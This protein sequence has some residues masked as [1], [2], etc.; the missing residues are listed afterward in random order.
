VWCEEKEIYKIKLPT[1]QDTEAFLSDSL[2]G[3]SMPSQIVLADEHLERVE[4]AEKNSRFI[5]VIH[6][7]RVNERIGQ[8]S[9]NYGKPVSAFVVDPPVM[10]GN[11]F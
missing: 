3:P 6:I 9:A 7:L 11:T 1:P 5:H 4:N 8:L 10:A 2:L